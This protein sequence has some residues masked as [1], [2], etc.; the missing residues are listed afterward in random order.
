MALQIIY[1]FSYETFVDVL[2]G[3]IDGLRLAIEHHE[4]EGWEAVLN[5]YEYRG[6]RRTE[7]ETVRLRYHNAIRQGAN[8]MARIEIMNQ[9]MDW[10]RMGELDAPLANAANATLNSLDDEQTLTIDN[11]EGRRIASLSKV[12]EMWN[13][14][15]WIIYDSY[16]SKGLQW[17]VSSLWRNQ[18][19]LVLPEYLRF[20]FPQGRAHNTL[21][22]FPIIGSPRQAALGFVYSSWLARALAEQLNNQDGMND[23]Q[24]FHIEMT[25]FQLGHEI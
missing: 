22:D 23:W 25:L 7:G 1:P 11:V 6:I 19:Q 16:S 13:P 5:R 14:S 10:G 4:S 18:Q 8:D 17:L 3:A 9:I 2:D 12:Y 15:R 20:P 21:D 24:A